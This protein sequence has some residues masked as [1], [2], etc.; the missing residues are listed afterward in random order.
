M[1]DEQNV[2][3][4]GATTIRGQ[5]KQ[6][7]E[8]RKQ[9]RKQ[10]IDARKENNKNK[11]SDNKEE[12]K[13]ANKSN[14]EIFKKLKEDLKE[15]NK[16]AVKRIKRNRRLKKRMCD[17]PIPDNV[18]RSLNTANVTIS[19]MEKVLQDMK[20]K[21]EDAVY[22]EERQTGLQKLN[23]AKMIYDTAPE[24]LR[25]AEENYYN[26]LGEKGG[27]NYSKFQTIRVNEILKHR[28][29][30]Y[31]EEYKRIKSILQTIQKETQS[32]KKEEMMSYLKDLKHMYQ[33]GSTQSEKDKVK[34]RMNL[35][36]ARRVAYYSEK[37]ISYYR[38]LNVVMHLL[39]IT[40]MVL[41]IGYNVI[42]NS[43]PYFMIPILV[44]YIIILTIYFIMSDRGVFHYIN[45]NNPSLG[46]RFRNNMML[47]YM[48]VKNLGI[49]KNAIPIG[50]LCVIFAFVGYRYG[51]TALIR[52]K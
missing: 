29:E 27:T 19:R 13:A 14:K 12:V 20:N 32:G 30:Q 22:D 25:N 18:M 11:T 33:T 16:E 49:T 5:R 1:S 45:E 40:T 2:N 6:K 7:R 37:D 46:E 42:F 31:D 50:I 24:I 43:F 26:L 38:L 35:N 34:E 15:K 10:K 3:L 36:I 41:Y 9:I 28:L 44:L 23:N 48:F 52:G 8:L 17:K 4:V 47:L 21:D 51:S 39:C